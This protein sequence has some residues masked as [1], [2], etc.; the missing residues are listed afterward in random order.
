MTA[1]YW[2]IVGLLITSLAWAGNAL[3]AR[4]AIGVLP[5]IGLSF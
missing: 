4:A 5:P 1:R 3:V 2:A